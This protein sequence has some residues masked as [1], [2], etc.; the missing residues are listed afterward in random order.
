MSSD[1]QKTANAANA[2]KSTGPK[3]PDGKTR[4]SRNSETHGLTSTKGRLLPDENPEEFEQLL[5]DLF[6]DYRSDYRDVREQVRMLGQVLWQ[7]NRGEY[8]VTGILNENYL[9]KKHLWLL[10]KEAGEMEMLKAKSSRPEAPPT[11]FEININELNAET[12][13]VQFGQSRSTVGILADL[14][15]DNRLEKVDRYT[16]RLFKRYLNLKKLLEPYSI[17]KDP[18]TSG[19]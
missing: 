8:C 10:L 14:H 4:S 5:Q 7:L 17:Q 3:T 6:S 12:E 9:E 16:K 1:R 19:E 2:Q 15:Q 18:V 11:E 13:V